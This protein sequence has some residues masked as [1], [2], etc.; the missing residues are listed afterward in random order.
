MSASGSDGRRPCGLR[1]GEDSCPGVQAARAAGMRTFGYAGGL[2]PA[3]R[4]KGPR[5]DRL[6]LTISEESRVRAGRRAA[7]A[8]KAPGCG[9][10]PVATVDRVG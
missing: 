6:P 3:E 10:A 7:G 5:H 4:L 2:T 1:R 8:E 9:E